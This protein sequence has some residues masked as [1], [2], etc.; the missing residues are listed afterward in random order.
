VKSL[1]RALAGEPVLVLGVVTAVLGA[2][3]ASE[4]WQKV[5][6][7]VVPLVLALIVRQV[8]VAPDTAVDAIQKAAMNTAAQLDNTTV[9]V[10]GSVTTAGEQIVNNT[11]TNVASTVGGIVGALA[12]SASDQKQK[13]GAVADVLIFI[14]AV[15]VISAVAGVACGACASGASPRHSA[16]VVTA[17]RDDCRRY[18]CDDQDDDGYRNVSPGPFDR[19]PVDVH[20][21]DIC[22]SPDCSRRGDAATTTTTRGRRR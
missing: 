3:G 10:A 14:G 18:D 19:S 6:G 5:A 1:L 11:V 7:A 21:N 16:T 17:H 20:D 4:D 15:V 12:P 8:V 22:I 9:G 13:G 2:L